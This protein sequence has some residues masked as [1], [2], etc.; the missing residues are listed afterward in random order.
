MNYSIEYTERAKQH[1]VEAVD[2]MAENAPIAAERWLDRLEAAVA[3]L[4]HNPERF[5]VAP[6]NDTHDIEIRQLLF[7]KRRGRYRI[8]FTIRDQTVTILDVR[9]GMRRWLEP[10][11]LDV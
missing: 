9:H 4:D 6:E 10:G 2:W 3:E 7:G 5:G 8:L 1:L 11:E